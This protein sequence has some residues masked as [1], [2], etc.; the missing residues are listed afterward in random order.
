MPLPE[1]AENAY[2]IAEY[3]VPANSLCGICAQVL[4]TL[5]NWLAMADYASMRPAEGHASKKVGVCE[6]EELKGRE[7]KSRN[8]SSSFLVYLFENH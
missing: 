7:T 5:V 3:A 4:F 1:P 2:S 6:E 8:Q